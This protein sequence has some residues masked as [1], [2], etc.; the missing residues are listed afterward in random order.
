MTG[1]STYA[2]KYAGYGIEKGQLSLFLKYMIE[3]RKLSAENRVFLD[4]LTFGDEVD[5]PEA[6]KLPVKL[7][8]A[9]LQNRKGEIDINLPISGSLDDPQFSVGGVIVKVILNLFVKAVTSPVA[10]LG[11]LFGGGDELAYVE[12]DYGYASIT[13]PMRERLKTLVKVLEDRPSLKLEIAGRID[14]ERDRE[15]LKRALMERRVKAQKQADLVKKGTESGSVDEIEVDA[16]EY[17]KYLE[18]AYKAEKFPKPRNFIGLVKDLPVEEMEKL[19]IANVKSGDDELRDLAERRAAAAR[20][21]FVTQ[22]KVP[23]ERV[24]TI[25]PHLTAKDGPQNDKARESRVDFLLK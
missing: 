20:E 10:L 12:F 1:F 17:P 14:P 21:W 22:G 8:V 25:Q 15:G 23:A 9:L 18:R 5:S 2:G 3:D 7:A 13:D 6:T 16:K 11:S 4:Q 19:M 24:F